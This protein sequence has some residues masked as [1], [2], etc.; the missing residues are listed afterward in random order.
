ME[1]NVRTI[2]AFREIFVG[3]KGLVDFATVDIMAKPMTRKSYNSIVSQVH[4]AFVDVASKSMKQAAEEVKMKEGTADIEASFDG[5]WQK[6]GHSSLNGIVSAIFISSGKV[7][8]Y[9]V[10]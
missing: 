7:L 3:Y 1:V 5:S 10:K 4:G 9:E 8:D 6:P 2:R